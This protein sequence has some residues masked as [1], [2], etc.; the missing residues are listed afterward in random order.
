M[1]AIVDQIEFLDSPAALA[2]L[3]MPLPDEPLAAVSVLRKVCSAEQAAAVLALRAVRRRA[4]ESGRFPPALAEQL[5]ADETM[6]QQASSYRLAVYLGRLLAGL[7]PAKEVFDLCCGMGSD[8][9]GLARAGLAVRA[10]DRSAAAVRCANHNFAALADL[11]PR[12]RAEQADVAGLDLP[13]AAAVNIDPDR[14]ASGRRAVRLEDY[15]PSA[16][17]LRGLPERTRAGSMK[18][19]PA[20][21]WQ[22]LADWPVAAAEYVSEADTCRQLRLWWGGAENAAPIGDN[23]SGRRFRLLA[24]CVHGA[25][26]DPQAATLE[27]GLAEAAPLGEPGPWLIEPDPAVIAAGA[28][29]DLA[30]AC[31]L[32]RYSRSLA[33]LFARQTVDTP[34]G[35]CYRIERTVPGRLRDVQR[36]VR[37]LGGG[38]VELKTRG[39]QLDT[40]ALA[41]ALRGPGDRPMVV[42][43]CRK[44]ARQVAFV[45]QREGNPPADQASK[46]TEP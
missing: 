45:G 9:I 28:V 29:D 37:E 34:L 19:S 31:G 46:N 14:R 35:R 42:L 1:S 10:F 26:G 7:S 15:S 4:G 36:A 11:A 20:L 8:A 12:P 44:G 33:W 21:H 3:A 27:A 41:P 23:G 40:D 25:M 43:W 5:L 22:V 32:W 13:P 24:T 38:F 30:A 2:L 18:L 17:F 6:L 39:V 16:E